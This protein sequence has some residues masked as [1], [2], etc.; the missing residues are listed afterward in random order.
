M[1][2]YRTD[3]DGL[4]AIAVLAVVYFH[5]N[6][7]KLDGGFL[8]VDM[9]F[10]ISGFLITGLTWKAMEQQQF[11]FSDFYVKRI[12]RLFPALFAMIFTFAAVILWVGLP[13]DIKNYGM[14]SLATSFYVSNIYFWSVSD[15]FNEAAKSDLLLHTWSLSVEEQFYVFF[16]AVLLLVFRFFRKKA[17]LI[18]LLMAVV[19]L[20]LSEWVLRTDP[21]MAFY[22]SP[23]RFW[24]FIAGGL[25]TFITL[26][27]DISVRLVSI[28]SWGFLLT[29]L[30]CFK[31]YSDSTDYPGINSVLPT[32]ATAGLIL[33]GA[34]EGNTASR[35]LSTK[36]MRFFGKISYSLYLWHWPLI[37]IYKMYYGELHGWA[38]FGLFLLTILLGYLSWRFIEE[39]FRHLN[40]RDFKPK[41]YFGALVLMSV[42]AV[43][44][45]IYIINNGFYDRYSIKALPIVKYLGTVETNNHPTDCFWS[46]DKSD[47]FP[48]NLC[49]KQSKS[50]KNVL[51]LGD[52]HMEHFAKGITEVFPEYEFSRVT[53]PG[54]RV[55]F[56]VKNSASCQQLMEP[57]F[58]EYL[59][60]Y[61]FDAI[62]ISGRWASSE[63]NKL[64]AS[65]DK[66]RLVYKGKIVLLGPIIEYKISF[67]RLLLR[68]IDADDANK[69]IDAFNK[70]QSIAR[71]DKEMEKIAKRKGVEYFSVLNALCNSAGEC[72]H[73]SKGEPI[74]VD[75]GHVT[76]YGSLFVMNA[77]KRSGQL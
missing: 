11:S 60:N 43:I 72:T 15:Y 39:P 18:F 50:K 2:A 5:L 28:L 35:F 71:L 4:R 22:I 64:E 77:L 52:S 33:L 41:I 42:S 73:I 48:K 19:F 67:P 25:V 63:L 27:K 14:S 12:R 24:Q 13:Q 38:M 10:V 65:L 29:L 75:Y 37:V 58:T 70:Y 21:S 31:E 47:T 56:P 40:I 1:K 59:K 23:T 51:L 68:Y 53:G 32:L 7:R 20:S 16:P 76:Y 49:I 8:G 6:P 26:R 69:H 30:V 62:V 57:I 17:I 3:I 34:I 55:L 46:L 74:H 66:I 9:F 44:S 45:T 36:L 61:H 54:C